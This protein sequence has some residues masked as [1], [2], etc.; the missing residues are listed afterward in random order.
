MVIVIF[1]LSLDRPWTARATEEVVSS[2]IASTPSRSYHCR[3][4][5]EAMSGLFWWSAVRISIGTLPILPPMSS[6]AM[7][8]A[9]TEPWPP[10]WAY[11]PDWSLR[12]PMRT[13][14]PENASA[15]P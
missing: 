12:T 2:M 11:R 9:S 8:A 14:L 3:A 6:T 10:Y 15:P 5:A 1:F 7:R 13:A 4:I